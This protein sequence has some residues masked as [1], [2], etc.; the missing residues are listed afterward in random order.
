MNKI[1]LSVKRLTTGLH[2]QLPCHWSKHPFLLNSFKIQ[3]HTQIKAIQ[4][5]ELPYIFLI[6][7]KSDNPP[8]PVLEE[9]IETQEQTNSDEDDAIKQLWL[10]KEQ[11]IEEQ[12]NYLRTLKKCESQFTQCLSMV[13]SINLKVGNQTQRAINDAHELVQRLID[14]LTV[15]DDTILHLME[16]GKAGDRY[17]NHA[18]NTTVLSLLLGNAMKLSQEE[19]L[20]LGLGAI[21]HDLGKNKIPTQILINIP[22]ISTAEKN[23]LKLHVRY[24]MEQVNS[25]PNFPPPSLQIIS[26]HHEYLDGSGYP[27][28]LN[29]DQISKLTQIFSVANEYDNMC[30]PTGQNKQSNPYR[31]LS[32]LYKHRNKQLNKSVVGLLIKELGIY[33]PGC[34]VLLSNDKFALVMSVI[35]SNLLQPKVLIYDADIPRNE[36]PIISLNEKGLSILRVISPSKLPDNVKEYLNLR[37][38]INYFF[39]IND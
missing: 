1:K 27:D 4:K 5:I 2:V 28:K 30:N 9:P 37:S 8:L 34:V 6:P 13:R 11:K 20:H 15:D 38:R 25:F 3:N 39:E 23:Y 14:S 19:L 36:A 17:F 35:K 7:N 10:K 24:G 22:N 12:K 21:F 26:Q 29:G 31:T 33:P 32:Q 16:E 18:L